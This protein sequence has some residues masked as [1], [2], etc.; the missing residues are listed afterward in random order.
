VR[1]LRPG[2]RPARSGYLHKALRSF[3]GVCRSPGNAIFVFGHSLDDND[4]HI[5]RYIERGGVKQIFVSL[6][7]DPASVANKKI[8]Q[9][10]LGMRD[11]RGA[12]GARYPLEVIFYD[13][14]SAQ[15]WG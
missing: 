3:E 12:R 15:V 4:R 1:E 5:F 7:G 10:A 14:A 2:P 8:I 13:A 11:R 9:A 6:F